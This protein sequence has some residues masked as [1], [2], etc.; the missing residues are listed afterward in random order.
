MFNKATLVGNVG[1]DPDIKSTNGGK[2]FARFRLA[3]SE[4]WRDRESGQKKEKTQW[5]NIVVWGDGLVEHVIEPYVRK[6]SRL[7]IEGQIQ[8]DIVGEGESAKYFT[9]IAVQGGR[10]TLVLLPS[11][12][13]ASRNGRDPTDDDAPP[14]YGR[15]GDPGPGGEGDYG[16]YGAYGSAPSGGNGAGRSNGGGAGKDLDQEIPF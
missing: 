3:T 5:H 1:S 13:S 8:Y 16:G 12:T 7:M 6:G 9:R 2:K 4:R 15:S 10:G 11:G 14:D